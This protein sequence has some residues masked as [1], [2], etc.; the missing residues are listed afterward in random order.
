MSGGRDDCY[1]LCYPH[2]Q[3]R[4][5]RRKVGMRLRLHGRQEFH[6][7]ALRKLDAGIGSC[8]NHNGKETYLA[9]QEVDYS[10]I[11][12]AMMLSFQDGWNL[13]ADLVDDPRFV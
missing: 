12:I 13:F 5:D 7:E 1:V 3:C 11:W 6:P 9:L 8:V 4:W 10:C 2:E